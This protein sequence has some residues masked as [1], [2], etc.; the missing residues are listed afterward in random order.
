MN[1]RLLRRLIWGPKTCP[2]CGGKAYLGETFCPH[3]GERIRNCNP[4][5]RFVVTVAAV[6]IVAAVVWWKLK[7]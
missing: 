6:G 3:C 7:W 2:D 4:V 5:V 1:D